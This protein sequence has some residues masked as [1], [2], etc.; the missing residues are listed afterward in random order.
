MTPSILSYHRATSYERGKLGG[1]S[2][3]WASQPDVFKKYLALDALKLD[4][5]AEM[6]PQKLLDLMRGKGEGEASRCI[7]RHLLSQILT[8]IAVSICLTLF[9]P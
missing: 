5:V 6:A 3:D 8:H 2:L 7:D 1:H 4:P 9:S